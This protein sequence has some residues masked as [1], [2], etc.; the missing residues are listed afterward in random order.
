MQQNIYPTGQQVSLTKTT[1]GQAF[2]QNIQN[3]PS[4]A[5]GAMKETM[6]GRTYPQ[7]MM[8]NQP[9][10]VSGTGATGAMLPGQ[11]TGYSS[12]G[13]QQQT[14][15]THQQATGYM[16]GQQVPLQ[17]T[18]AENVCYGAQ[19][20]SN[21]PE[22]IT[23]VSVTTQ[24]VPMAGHTHTQHVPMAAHTHAQQVPVVAHTHA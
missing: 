10:M 19:H 12:G 3:L 8:G 23:Q 20:F 22:T 2:N 6:T 1:S 18:N 13:L 7:N 5:M 16:S 4:E 21:Q 17:T 14:Y 24:Q 9:G 11:A 15:T